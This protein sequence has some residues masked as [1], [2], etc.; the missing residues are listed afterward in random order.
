[1]RESALPIPAPSDKSG[2]MWEWLIKGCA[3][4]GGLYH[5]EIYARMVSQAV[6]GDVSRW[7]VMSYNLVAGI[8]GLVAFYRL[9]KL[10]RWAAI[11]MCLGIWAGG[12]SALVQGFE[13]TSRESPWILLAFSI[14]S[15]ALVCGRKELKSGF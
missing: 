7:G 3:I 12:T 5:A 1:M 14:G 4:A 8:V 13:G 10:K 9:F 6:N 2:E 15:L 11:L